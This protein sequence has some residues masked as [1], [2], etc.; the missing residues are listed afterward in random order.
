MK[1]YNVVIQVSI[2]GNE[3]IDAFIEISKAIAK[4]PG[5]EIKY[6]QDVEPEEVH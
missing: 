5:V 3:M 2:E 1:T 4:I 6:I